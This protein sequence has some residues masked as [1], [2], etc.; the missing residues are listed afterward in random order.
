M[1]T[2]TQSAVAEENTATEIPALYTFS[3]ALADAVARA[4]R[5]IVRVDDGTRMT[6]SGLIWHVENETAFVVA[7][8]HGV[9]RDDDISVEL[10]DGQ[11][12]RARL[13][14]RDDDTDC[15]VLAL[16]DS[17]ASAANLTPISAAPDSSV[18]VGNVAIA[19]ARPGDMGLQATLGLVSARRD[20]QTDGSPEFILQTDA[21]L[22][23]GFSGGALVDVQGRMVGLLNRMFGRGIGVALG[24][25]MVAR[26]VDAILEQ[27]RVRRGYLGIRMQLVQLPVSLQTQVGQTHGLLVIHLAEGGPAS[28]GGLLL[29]DTLLHVNGR[30]LADVDALRPHLKAG[31]NV[32]LRLVRGG[33]LRELSL[34]VGEQQ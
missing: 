30:P 1:A 34:T 22:Y 13:V 33:E 18:R 16:G 21:A 2:N 5:S 3:D 14:G 23:P 25:P 20:T 10:S 26:V 32:S 11:S 4:E 27:G 12:F 6:A 9:E 8:S 24:T 29:G 28:E 7:T 31:Q 19:L 15:A 17:G